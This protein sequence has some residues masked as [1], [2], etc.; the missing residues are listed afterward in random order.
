M[1]SQF[2]TDSKLWMMTENKMNQWSSPACLSKCLVLKVTHLVSSIS[3]LT[4]STCIID[5]YERLKKDKITDDF[6]ICSMTLY[7]K[8]SDSHQSIILHMLHFI[9]ITTTASFCIC[10]TSSIKKKW[11]RSFSDTLTWIYS[12]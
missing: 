8:L 10:I 9:L 3:W 7:N 6:K 1:L 2:A 12:N 5:I 11:T 4:S